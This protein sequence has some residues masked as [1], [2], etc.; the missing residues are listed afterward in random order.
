MLGIP[1]GTLD[2]VGLNDGV[3]VGMLDMVGL[4]EGASDGRLE[5]MCDTEGEVLGDT[6]MV[7]LGVVGLAVGLS[8]ATASAA[9]AFRLASFDMYI[10]MMTALKRTSATTMQIITFLVRQPQPQP[11][12]SNSFS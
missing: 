6:D 3:P 12:V 5:G 9:A 1:E 4:N 10:G 2:A 7:G 11:L 8:V